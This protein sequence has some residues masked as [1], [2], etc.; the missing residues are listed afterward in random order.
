MAG[1]ERDRADMTANIERLEKEKRELQKFNARIIKENRSLLDKLEKVN[2]TVAASDAYAQSLASALE[3]TNLEVRRLT[4]MASRAE[5]LERQ[6]VELE[7]EQAETQNALGDSRA[8]QKSLAQRLK[9]AER[10]VADLQDQNDRIEREA[11]EEREKHDETISRLRRRHVSGRGNELRGIT[12]GE[13]D[14]KGP[15]VV[16]VA[17][18]D[19]FVPMSFKKSGG[20]VTSQYVHGVLEDN[21]NLHKDVVELRQMLLNANV[22]METLREQL[23]YHQPL[24]DD[25][26]DSSSFYRNYDD[27]NL[28][29]TM[30]ANIPTLEE[31]LSSTPNIQKS[32]AVHIHHPQYRARPA[33]RD[34]NR[35]TSQLRVG[36]ERRVR[37]AITHK[38]HFFT[39]PMSPTPCTSVP[40]RDKMRPTIQVPAKRASTY[41]TQTLTS[42]IMST[43]TS[44]S[45]LSLS[46]APS[47]PFSANQDSSSLFEKAIGFQ[48]AGTNGAYPVTPHSSAAGSPPPLE[49]L[50]MRRPTGFADLDATVCL[51]AP[52][53][54]AKLCLTSISGSGSANAAGTRR[55]SVQSQSTATV[56][57]YGSI[58]LPKELQ[59]NFP[60]SD[61]TARADSLHADKTTDADMKSANFSISSMGSAEDA[62]KSTNMDRSRATAYRA[63]ATHARRSSVASFISVSGMD[64][65]THT[66][67][68]T[69]SQ[70][71]AKD[72]SSPQKSQRQPRVARRPGL[73]PLPSTLFLSQPTPTN[74]IST[75]TTTAATPATTT[76]TT[77]VEVKDAFG[78]T[79]LRH[80]HSKG[81]AVLSGLAS[82]IKG[83]RGDVTRMANNNN[84]N[85]NKSRTTVM[86]TTTTATTATRPTTP[87]SPKP[88][89]TKS[90]PKMRSTGVNQEGSLFWMGAGVGAGAGRGAGRGAEDGK[91]VTV[92]MVDEVALRECLQG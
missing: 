2:G 58:K 42:G 59:Q 34:R 40:R 41:S 19:A 86:M 75:T 7:V 63:C 54:D 69:H 72:T 68:E 65:H 90:T 52:S 46:S 10:T 15:A 81:H 61:M 11:M 60:P 5:T 38:E 29:D 8:A 21:A 44:T 77:R 80:E 23:M 79:G 36:K 32:P 67:A 3:A 57:R 70:A 53:N 37:S 17:S 91:G 25:L 18:A 87:K 51:P 24:Y 4:H 12:W 9:R 78:S 83:A 49:A 64:I 43:T 92:S 74:A 82:A 62:A 6:L 47:S 56:S 33:A 22:E 14:T 16:G 45:A 20:D 76:T 35:E 13:D 1:S 27:N 55:N 88:K 26:T 84:N 66:D 85:N 28:D 89:K 31:D 30:P 71:Q 48:A 50:Q 73:R 39:P